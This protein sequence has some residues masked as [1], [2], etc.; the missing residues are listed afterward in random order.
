M[1]GKDRFIN[2]INLVDSYRIYLDVEFF[3]K[4]RE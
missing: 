2:Y 1:P 3:K 4:L